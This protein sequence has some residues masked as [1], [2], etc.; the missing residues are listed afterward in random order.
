VNED[1]ELNIPRRDRVRFGHI[2][3]SEAMKEMYHQLY[4]NEIYPKKLQQTIESHVVSSITQEAKGVERRRH[5]NSVSVA[6]MSVS[7]LQNEEH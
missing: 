5:T 6:S 3:Q 1:R 4:C 7:L 2:L